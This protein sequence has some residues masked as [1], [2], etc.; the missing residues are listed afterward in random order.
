MCGITGAVVWGK[1]ERKYSEEVLRRMAAPLQ[2]RGPDGEGYFYEA[3][4]SVEVALAHKR[5][6]IIDLSEGGAQPMQSRSRKSTIVFNGEIYNYRALKQELAAAGCVFSSHS[7]TE[8]ILEGFEIWGME[9]LLDKLD[10]MFAFALYVADK[11]EFYLA[12]DRFGKKPLYF[13][14]K[15]A[16]LAFSSDIR[17]FAAAGLHCSLDTAALGY[18]FAEL[19]TPLLDTIY[20]EVKRLAPSHYLRASKENIEI[21][22]YWKLD[23]ADSCTLSRGE[24]IDKTDEL[25]KAAVAKRLVAD[26]NVAAQ[27]S[28]G[29]DSSLIVAMMAQQ[30]PVPVATYSVGFEHKY[31]NETPFARQVAERYK[32]D[33]HELIMRPEDISVS[34]DLILEYGE[35]FADVSMIPS[36]MIS[37]Y[38]SQ[39]EKVVCGGDGGDELFSGYH[40]FYV[41]DKLAK[42]KKY[43]FLAPLAKLLSKVVPTYRTQ[44]LSR[45][46][47]LGRQPEWHLLNRN[48]GF[49]PAQMKLL[50]PSLPT[51][52]TALE[53]QHAPLWAE[54]QK[55]TAPLLKKVLHASLSTRLVNDYLVKV[56]R[57]SMYAGLE[58]RS[59]FLDKDLA[60]FAFTLSPAQMMS[61]HG[62]KSVLKTLAERYLPHDLIYRN[63]QGFGVPIDDWF[64]KELRADFQQLVLDGRQ[65]LVPLN[66]DYIGQLLDQ[67]AKG[68]DHTHR[69]WTLYV[70]HTW[71]NANH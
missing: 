4:G 29:I 39:T 57:A 13:Y 63:K 8:V 23:Y 34:K 19:S 2:F 24:I 5:L 16:E 52:H 31:Y 69:L 28:G 56:D 67:H 1:V 42:V 68:A 53:A 64:R 30:S 33:H 36:Y 44:F 26:V 51:M 50:A 22:R 59:P 41:V 18:Y 71:A 32:T 58:M 27:L 66:Y 25:L 17:S 38:I 12:R 65:K 45:L 11:E 7:D 15:A 60:A 14:T 20:Q 37:K 47:D 62:N 21:K 3:A 40:S 9:K 54:Y 46:L 6:S 55:T 35:P 61:P 70:F 43:S 48:M 10:G 49:S